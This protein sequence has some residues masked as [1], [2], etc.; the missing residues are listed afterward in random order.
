M[1]K[2]SI[3]YPESKPYLISIL[4]SHMIDLLLFEE[5]LELLNYLYSLGNITEN[6]IEWIAKEYFERNSIKTKDFEAIILYK[7]NKRAILILNERG[8][9]VE[10]TPE[11]QR[12]IANSKEAKTILT[13]TVN[14]YNNIVGFIGYEKSNKYLVFKTKDLL[15]KR[16]TGARCDEAGKDKTMK[17][18]NEIIGEDKYTNETTKMQKDAKGNVTREA[19]GQIE[20]CVM[21]EFILRYFEMIKKD[22]KKWFLTPELAIFFKLYTIFV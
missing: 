13:F 18:L 20:L 17:K 14:E 5:K 15:A 11:D 22:G 19:V 3:E 8:I 9:W 6:S 21:Q 16:D 1:R 7:L 10:A 4:L 12:E 2:M